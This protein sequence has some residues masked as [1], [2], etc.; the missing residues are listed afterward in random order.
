[1]NKKDIINEVAK[2]VSTR[3]EAKDVIER[4]IASIKK[5]LAENERVLITGFGTFYLQLCKPKKGRNPKTGVTV[6]IP[7]RKVIK[8]RPARN[9]FGK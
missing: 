6:E 9:F 5:A 4:I 8:F 7:A 1:M 3:K 2:I